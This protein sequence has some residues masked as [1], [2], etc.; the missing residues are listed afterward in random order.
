MA[1]Q[2]H[3]VLE[4]AQ[5]ALSVVAESLHTL[6]DFL[7]PLD[8]KLAPFRAQAT[9]LHTEHE[10]CAAAVKI[11]DGI[12]AAID[13]CNTAQSDLLALRRRGDVVGHAKRLRSLTAALETLSEYEETEGA[14]PAARYGSS[15]L[16]SAVRSALSDVSDLASS[17]DV[18]APQL[19]VIGPF[20]LV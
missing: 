9:A 20:W 6:D 2:N 1:E 11:L 10:R 18:E 7:E 8:S 17:I 12:V 16:E 3:D 15:L 19:K 5:Q 13:N 14:G 4:T